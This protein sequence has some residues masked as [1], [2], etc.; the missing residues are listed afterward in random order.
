MHA[1]GYI[2]LDASCGVWWMGDTVLGNRDGFSVG[3]GEVA[4]E[5]IH[6]SQLSCHHYS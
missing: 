4:E 6:P 1:F 3:R 5:E 2:F